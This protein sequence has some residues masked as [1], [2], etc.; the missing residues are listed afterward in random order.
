[1]LLALGGELRQAVDDRPKVG[2]AIA[3][4][5]LDSASAED[6]Q[7]RLADGLVPEYFMI[8]FISAAAP[9]VTTKPFS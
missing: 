2:A 8:S 6:F 7:I 1:M 9:R 3:E 4:E 5:I